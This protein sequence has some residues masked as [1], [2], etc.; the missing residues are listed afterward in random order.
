[1]AHRTPRVEQNTNNIAQTHVPRGDEATVGIGSTARIAAL[2]DAFRRTFLGGHVVET[3][4]VLALPEAERIA[5]LLAVR[6]FSAFDT[7]NDPHGEHD[8]GT[9]EVGGRRCFWKIDTY[10]RA[11]RA[12]SPDP[13]DPAVTTRVLT[14]MLAEEY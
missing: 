1:M 7:G 14:I 12:H 13:T 10:D 8:F 2:N 5:L 9:V 3:P 6:R 11:L 4:S